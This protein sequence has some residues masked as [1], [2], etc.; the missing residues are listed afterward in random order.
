MSEGKFLYIVD[1]RPALERLRK[2]RLVPPEGSGLV[3]TVTD[4]SYK[5]KFNKKGLW[6]T[7]SML[8]ILIS[9]KKPDDETSS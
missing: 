3:I 4:T 6:R 8:P 2:P 1:L 5:P 9:D 7:A